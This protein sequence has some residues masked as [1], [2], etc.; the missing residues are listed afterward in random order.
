MFSHKFHS[1]RLKT[2]ITLSCKFPKKHTPDEQSMLDG[3]LTN[4]FDQKNFPIGR[5]ML[6]EGWG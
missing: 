5:Q 6:I 3:I 2:N 4:I 1:M